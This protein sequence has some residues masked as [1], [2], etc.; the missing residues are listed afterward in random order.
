VPA[1]TDPNPFRNLRLTH[2][3]S[4]LHHIY[5][6]NRQVSMIEYLHVFGRV[7]SEQLWNFGAQLDLLN[8]NHHDADE[9]PDILIIR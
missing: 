5:T 1:L 7:R 4:Y 3:P 6:A 9:D 8:T 2:T